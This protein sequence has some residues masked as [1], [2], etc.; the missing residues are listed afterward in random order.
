MLQP[1][2]RGSEVF[3]S[4]VVGFVSY[5]AFIIDATSTDQPTPTA[6]LYGLILS[7][8]ARSSSFG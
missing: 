8:H 2:L 3:A 1:D 6:R 4:R 5:V 7:P